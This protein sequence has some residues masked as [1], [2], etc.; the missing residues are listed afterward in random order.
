MNRVFSNQ[1]P[2]PNEIINL[3]RKD[4]VNSEEYDDL[5]AAEINFSLSDEDDTA[6][7]TKSIDLPS[8]QDRAPPSYDELYPL[9]SDQSDILSFYNR[10]I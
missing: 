8:T 6:T 2:Y 5:V 10:N 4:S 7:S 1:N 9:E 3:Y